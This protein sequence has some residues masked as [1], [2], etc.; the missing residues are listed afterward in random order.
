MPRHRQ[1]LEGRPNCSTLQSKNEVRGGASDPPVVTQL[2]GQGQDSKLG[3]AG[4][5]VHGPPTIPEPSLELY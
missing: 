3:P 5:G 4:L 2:A 1:A